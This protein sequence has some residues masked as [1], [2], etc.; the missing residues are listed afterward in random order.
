M[1]SK[2]SKSYF[3]SIVTNDL[4][5]YE[6]LSIPASYTVTHSVVFSVTTQAE[7]SLL[8]QKFGCFPCA[9]QN[10]YS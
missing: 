2:Y 9:Y 6:V 3:F 8:R 7:V 5:Q 10:M 1:N 4:Y